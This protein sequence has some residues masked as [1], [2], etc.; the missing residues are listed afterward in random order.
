MTLK[1][2]QMP[3]FSFTSVICVSY[4]ISLRFINFTHLFK[5]QSFG[6]LL[7]NIVLNN[8]CLY[9]FFSSVIWVKRT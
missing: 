4:L 6:M 8:C 3:H 5:E 1:F 2:M 9:Y 7:L